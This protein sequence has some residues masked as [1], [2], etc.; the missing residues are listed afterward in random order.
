[1]LRSLAVVLGFVAAV[2][3]LSVFTRQQPP[4]P[5]H[6]VDYSAAL[7]A[8]RRTAS[9]RVLAPEPPP[10][11]WRATSVSA[12]GDAGGF[13]W[14]LGFLTRDTQYVGL[15][16]SDVRPAAFVAAKTEGSSADGTVLLRGV[17]W[18]RRLDP[19]RSERSLVRVAAGVAT[20]VTGTTS[21]PR[22]S[23]FASSLR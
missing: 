22:L 1:M 9:Y 13:T 5:V 16:Q 15:E 3:A 23:V 19:G 20:V 8:A 4:D 10:P 12:S 14:H 6:P 18:E 11:G 17:R 7:D 21:Y 2:G